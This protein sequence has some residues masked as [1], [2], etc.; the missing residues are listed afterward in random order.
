MNKH[1]PILLLGTEVKHYDWGHPTVI[2]DIIGTPPLDAPG[3]ELWMGAHP[4]GSS[5]ILETGKRLID[6]IADD[7]M[8]FL[9]EV[10]AQKGMETLPFLLKLLAV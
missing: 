1:S 6:A 10:L 2:Y 8:G 5:V 9:G 4:S 3:A 7:K